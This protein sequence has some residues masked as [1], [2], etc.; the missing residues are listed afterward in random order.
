MLKY[1]VLQIDFVIFWPLYN[2]V[3][4]FL[5]QCSTQPCNTY[6]NVESVSSFKNK[7]G[8]VRDT[9]TC[10]YNQKKL[11]E[12]FLTRSSVKSDKM[13]I[14]HCIL[15]PMLIIAMSV[16]LLGTLFCR[17]KGHCCFKKTNGSS[18]PYQGLQPTT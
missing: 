3:V 13:K 5:L 1:V 9:Y 10:F 17:S 4:I 6:G 2:I 18:V 8:Q 7:F 12:V 16:G 14:L 11:D 15:W